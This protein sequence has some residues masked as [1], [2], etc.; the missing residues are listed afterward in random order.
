MSKRKSKPRIVAFIPARYL[1]TRFPGKPLAPIAGKPM[2]QHVYERV[3]AAQKVDEAYV[4]TDD[5]RIAEAVKGFGGTFLMTSSKLKSGTDRCAAGAQMINPEVVVNVQGDE[6]L[7]S[8]RT[9]DST[10]NELLESPQDVMSTAAV[11]IKEESILF[12]ENTVKVAVSI[13]KHA[14]YFSRN[15]I[16]FIRGKK[17]DEYLKQFQFLKHIGLYVYRNEFL[18]RFS[19]L[20]ETPLEKAEKLEQLRALENGYRIKVAVV[21]ED[22]IPVDIPEDILEVETYLLQKENSSMNRRLFI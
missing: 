6:P 15:V 9:I 13:D 1:S 18:Q 8:P 21:K 19:K 17:R 11:P 14:L 10:I 3:L 5:I 2:I 20:K 4:L 12:S 16:P 7:I 22:T